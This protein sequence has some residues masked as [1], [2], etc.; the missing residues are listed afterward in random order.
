MSSSALI[1]WS[2]CKQPI[3]AR[4]STKAEYK[5]VANAT[6]ELLWISSL[7]CDLCVP[8]HSDPL[9][10]CDNHGATYLKANP[11]LHAHTKHVTVYC[12]FVRDRVASKS[13]V[14]LF[15]SSKDQPRHFNQTFIYYMV[16]C[17]LFEPFYHFSSA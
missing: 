17:S 10:W 7:L 9:L 12:H 14:V 15:L 2:S 8:L 1:S 5:V 13:L 3:I 4:S 11:I 16:L 6:C